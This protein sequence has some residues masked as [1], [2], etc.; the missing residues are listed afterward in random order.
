VPVTAVDGDRAALERVKRQQ[1]GVQEVA[2][3]VRELSDRSISPVDLDSA[4][5]RRVFGNRAGNSPS[6][7][8]FQHVKFFRGNGVLALDGDFGDGLA[9]V[10]VIVHHLGRMLNPS[11]RSSRHAHRPTCRWPSPKTACRWSR[12]GAFR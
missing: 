11:V 10:A 8:R 1:R 3:F 5:M 4:V 9:D 6:R 2:D 12:A 7:Q